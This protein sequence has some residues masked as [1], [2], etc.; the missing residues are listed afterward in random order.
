MLVHS[1]SKILRSD[2]RFWGLFPDAAVAEVYKDEERK[3]SGKLYEVLEFVI[4]KDS[5]SLLDLKANQKVIILPLYGN[6]RINNFNK[7]IE[8]GEVVIFES[9]EDQKVMVRNVREDADADVLIMT[10]NKNVSKN[11]YRINK[12]DLSIRNRLNFIDSGFGFPGFIGIFDGRET[13]NYVL[14]KENSSIFGMVINGAFEFQ[15]RLLENRDAVL[16]NNLDELE[17]EALSEN[18]LILFLE[19]PNA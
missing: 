12:I 2:H 14:K 4:Y 16:I 8:A 5:Q 18:A 9:S 7:I 11:S 17:F 3:C 13:G 10:F 6:I 1:P 15:D 19:I